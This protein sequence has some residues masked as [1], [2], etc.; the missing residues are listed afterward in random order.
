MYIAV[1]C[2]T[3][4]KSIWDQEENTIA[5]IIQFTGKNIPNKRVR[6][7]DRLVFENHNVI[8]KK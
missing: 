7:S 8:V 6:E 2:G 1:P 3:V 5:E 4:E